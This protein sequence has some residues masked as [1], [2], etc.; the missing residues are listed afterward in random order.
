MARY[1]GCGLN[2]PLSSD[3]LHSYFA[4][5][6]HIRYYIGLKV[7]WHSSS[8]NL[9]SGLILG[10]V[11]GSPWNHSLPKCDKVRD[12]YFLSMRTGTFQWYVYS[13]LCGFCK[14]SKIFQWARMKEW[15]TFVR[16]GTRRGNRFCL[17]KWKSPSQGKRGLW[18]EIH[19]TLDPQ[20]SSIL[21]SRN[22]SLKVKESSLAPS[23]AEKFMTMLLWLWG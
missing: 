10:K 15:R 8:W 1:D 16:W 20:F 21:E 7:N 14:S 22:L 2:R 13:F 17:R 18:G 3:D 12:I 19:A 11:M 9:Q 6:R 23:T 4:D 5:I